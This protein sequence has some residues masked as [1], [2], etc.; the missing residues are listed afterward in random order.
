MMPL[1]DTHCHLNFAEFDE[2]RGAVIERAVAAGVT[3]ILI[4]GT[5]RMQPPFPAAVSTIQF[6]YGFGLH[7]Y[8]INQHDVTDLAWLETQLSEHPRAFVG[9]IGLDKTCADYPLQQQLFK[10]QVELAVQYQR[11]LILHHRKSQP[12]LLQLLRPSLS[13]LGAHPGV[14]HAFSGSYEQ[15]MDWVDAGF[16]LGVGGV[17]TYPRAMKTRAAIA[18]VPS[19]ALVLETDAPAMPLNGSQGQRNEPSQI[20]RV[21][22]ELARLRDCDTAELSEILWHNSQA[23]LR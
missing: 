14:L 6:H 2:D 1:F 9:E 19:S 17:I 5:Q 8:F 4:P 16:K 11:P 10:A 23:L 7:P 3:A 22:E 18:R 15:A 20:P 12:D 13:Q 21:L